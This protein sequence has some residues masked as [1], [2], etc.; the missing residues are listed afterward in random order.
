MKRSVLGWEVAGIIFIIFVGSFMHFAYELAGHW[1]PLSLIAA[2]NEST[3][4]HLKLAFWPGL[5]FYIFE[6]KFLRKSTNNFLVAKTV[7]LYLMPLAIV[8]L[9][10]SY[11]A[12]LGEDFFIMDI[13][14]FMLAV[15]IGQ[16]ASYKLLTSDKLPQIWH[17]LALV[18]LILAILA[19]S[20]L[21]FYAP[22]FFLFEDPVTGGYG[23][24]H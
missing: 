23:I 15:V 10:Y 21:T 6:F 9:F 4:E 5:I 7:S 18:F 24:I 11:T 12:I 14:I 13:L 8:A 3:W 1:E 2:V 20:L 22:E 19:F 16:L 17:K